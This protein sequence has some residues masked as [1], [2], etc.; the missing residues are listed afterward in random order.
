MRLMVFT[1]RK[2]V[3]ILKN[4]WNLVLVAI[5]ALILGLV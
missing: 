2:D 4:N 1:S 5:T 3:N